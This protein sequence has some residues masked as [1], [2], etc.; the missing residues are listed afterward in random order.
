M[1]DVRL[2][3]ATLDD[4]DAWFALRDAVARE[5]IYIGAE[6]PLDRDAH[7]AIYASWL[8]TDDSTVFLAVCDA[9]G[10]EVLVGSLGAQHAH[11]VVHL[12]MWVAA[13]H[14]RRGIGRALLDACVAWARAQGAHKVALEAWPHNGAA[15]ALYE[16][17]G[18]VHE[19]RLRRQWRRRDGSL[20]DAVAMALVLDED[21]P[22]C[23]Y[24]DA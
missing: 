14:R 20:W 2:R 23:P 8:A 13:D 24:P 17:A 7:R 1:G 3:T 12:G 11:G 21:A 16:R 6:A 18:F 9:D 19:G 4:F 22:G 10:E 15:I 5:G